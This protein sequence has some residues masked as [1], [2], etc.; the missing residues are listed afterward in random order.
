MPTPDW[1][2]LDDFLGDFAV[3]A[4]ITPQSGP[5]RQVRGIY[6]DQYLNGITGE[7]EADSSRPRFSC[8]FDDVAGLKRADTINVPG[9]GVFKLM[10]EPQPD[11]IGMA[12]LEMA[13]DAGD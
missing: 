2:N 1:D 3:V 7:Y 13:R 5:V 8:K 4:T 12:K 10:T 11:G 6:D 9:E